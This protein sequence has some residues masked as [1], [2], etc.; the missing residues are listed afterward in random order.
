MSAPETE[1]LRVHVDYGSPGGY[2]LEVT[3]EDGRFAGARDVHV[4]LN[5]ELVAIV[6]AADTLD[7]SVDVLA[8]EVVVRHELDV[9]RVVDAA[10]R[11][12]RGAWAVCVGEEASA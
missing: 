10:E 5:G 12:W 9:S 3:R 8:P 11:A 6:V 7:A 1:T 2:V 4:R